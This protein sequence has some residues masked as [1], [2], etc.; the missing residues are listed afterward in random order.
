MTSADQYIRLPKVLKLMGVS[1]PTLYAQILKG[2]FPRPMRVGDRAVAWLEAD[3]HMI[4][5]ARRVECSN[6]DLAALVIEMREEA[7]KAAADMLR[8]SA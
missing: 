2:L 8:K 3:V 4:L 1:R 7:K 5:A 6:K